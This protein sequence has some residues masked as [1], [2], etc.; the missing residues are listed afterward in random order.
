[1][2]TD[3]DARTEVKSNLTLHGFTQ[4]GRSVS[5]CQEQSI[6]SFEGELASPKN[7]YLLIAFTC[8]PDGK[9]RSY[10]GRREAYWSL[11]PQG[12]VVHESGPSAAQAPPR[13]RNKKHYMVIFRYVR[14][15][16]NTLSIIET[17]I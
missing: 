1:M 3:V 6:I 10:L 16:Y 14:Q 13:V 17:Q 15:N 8:I 9:K 12:L 7:L 2:R 5:T 4:I 11:A